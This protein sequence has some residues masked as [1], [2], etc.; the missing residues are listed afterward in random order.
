MHVPIKRTN[1]PNTRDACSSHG[2]ECNTAGD[3]T[4]KKKKLV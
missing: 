3:V 1:L 4:A 2:S